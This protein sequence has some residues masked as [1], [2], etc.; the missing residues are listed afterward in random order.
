[1]PFKLIKGSFRVVGLSPDG[2]S[3]RFFPDQPDVMNGLPGG[4]DNQPQ[5]PFAQLRLE[6]IDAL[7]THYAGRHQPIRWA[8]AARDRLLDFVGVTG[9]QWDAT[10]STIVAASDGTTRGSILSRAKDKYGRPIAFVFADELEG[11]DGS[12]VRLDVAQLRDSYNH[13]ALREGLA[14]PTYYEGLFPD[15]RNELTAVTQQA[16]ADGLGLWP[17]DRTT[18]GVDATRLSVIMDDAPIL[19]KLFRRL[20]D[21][22]AAKGTAVGFRDALAAGR[23]AVLDLQTMGFT[24]LDT[25]VEQAAGSSFVRLTRNPEELVFDPMPQ[26]AGNFFAAMVGAP[27]SGDAEATA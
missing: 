2:D 24:H 20:S 16:R 4:P 8:R 15:L 25:F 5:R 26:R 27:I 3:I 19:P 21:Y 12:D 1:M 14:Y 13:L 17:E 6:A 10:G 22:M 11:E 9:V 7:E 18:S 23:D